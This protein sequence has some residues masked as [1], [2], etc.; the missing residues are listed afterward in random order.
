MIPAYCIHYEASNDGSGLSLQTFT[1]MDECPDS[2]KPSS[3]SVK[4]ALSLLGLDY[5]LLLPLARDQVNTSGTVF[6]DTYWN[7]HAPENH[8][9]PA[10]PE[11]IKYLVDQTVSELYSNKTQH[12]VYKEIPLDPNKTVQDQGPWTDW[13]ITISLRVDKLFTNQPIAVNFDLGFYDNVALREGFW[14]IIGWSKWDNM[15]RIPRMSGIFDRYL[16]A[17]FS[18]GDPPRDLETPRKRTTMRYKTSKRDM[19]AEKWLQS[20]ELVFR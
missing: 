12:R 20:N 15:H 13:A 11:L 16:D 8:N 14:P 5:D 17:V 2:L 4:K 18:T 7:G 9:P 1:T 3:E 19:R 10:Y 6:H